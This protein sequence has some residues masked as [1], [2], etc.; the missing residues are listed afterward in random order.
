MER[1]LVTSDG[2][3]FKPS[4]IGIPSN[5]LKTGISSV[6]EEAPQE[7]K[8]LN[9]SVG[10]DIAEKVAA[11]FGMKIERVQD[12]Y[13]PYWL[14]KYRNRRVLVDGITKRM[15]TEATKE[16]TGTIR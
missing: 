8:S 12:A 9:F 1:G 7:G 14:L 5:L 15:D 3:S 16:V 2:H 10:R 4:K 6:P 11:L 13:I